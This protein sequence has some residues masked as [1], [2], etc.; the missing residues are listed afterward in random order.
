MRILL[1][2]LPLVPL[3]AADLTA[4]RAPG[5]GIQPQA[6]VAADGSVHLIWYR[7]PELAGDLYYAVRAPGAEAFTPPLRVDSIPGSAV[8]IGAIRGAQLALGR[9]GW[10]HVAWN[11]SPRMTQKGPEGSP[12]LCY[13]RKARDAAGFE[14]QRDLMTWAAG[15]DGGGTIAA[16]ARGR[17]CVAWHAGPGKAPEA[18]RRVVA[19]VSQDDGRT[20]A[21]EADAV[22]TRTGACSCC[23]MRAAF[24]GEGGIALLYRAATGGMA[25]DMMLAYRPSAGVDA[26]LTRLD[27]WQLG[28]CPMST[29]AAVPA[30]DGLLIAWQG[31]SG[32]SWTRVVKGVAGRPVAL[33]RGDGAKHPAIA[34]S[35]DGTI[36]VVWTEGTGW[37][38]G[39]SLHW[40]LYAADGSAVGDPGR[41]E[42]VPVWSIPTVVATGAGRFEAWY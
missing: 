34:E 33:P 18:E 20:F 28:T 30:H 31:E 1:A 39:G 7:G 29:A 41:Q 36:A 38:R 3:T 15:L 6:A 27:A 2:I 32:L 19:A 9:D 35:A 17:V 40:Q 4:G 26:K 22:G 11:G 13:A 37:K 16:D 8:S 14:P 23:A 5:D 24:D 21:K 12:P 10:I 25:R 42:G